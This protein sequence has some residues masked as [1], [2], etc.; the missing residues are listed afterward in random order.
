MGLPCG[1]WIVG[2]EEWKQG[3]QFKLL[4]L[5]GHQVIVDKPGVLAVN[6]ERRGR[7]NTFA[8]K[9]KSME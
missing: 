9:V 6:V 3:Q 7:I 4:Q 5:C 1:E 8:A 2:G